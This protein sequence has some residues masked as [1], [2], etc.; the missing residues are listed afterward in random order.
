M[1]MSRKRRSIAR[2]DDR[3]GE[4]QIRKLFVAAATLSLLVGAPAF[5]APCKDAKTGKFIS[6]RRS[7][8]GCPLQGREGQVR[9]VRHAWRE[10]DLM[11]RA[12]VRPPPQPP[13]QP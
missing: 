6:A 7:R 9:E 5:A 10:G 8:N 11:R 13:R 4:C 2:P 12:V 3:A 1:T